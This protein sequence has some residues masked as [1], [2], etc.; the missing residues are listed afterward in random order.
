MLKQILITVGV[1]LAVLVI[2]QNVKMDDE[3]L[4]EKLEF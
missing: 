3:T 2:V 1:V 4:L